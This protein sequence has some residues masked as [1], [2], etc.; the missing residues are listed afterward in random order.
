MP[1]GRGRFQDSFLG[2]D[3]LTTGVSVASF[4]VG[5]RSRFG[6]F[7]CRLL[8]ANHELGRIRP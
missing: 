1:I 4:L 8:T 5:S 2:L 7:S 3:I 6:S